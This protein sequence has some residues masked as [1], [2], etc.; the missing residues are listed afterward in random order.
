MN[1]LILFGFF[2]CGL[3]L[4]LA[5]PQ[6]DD[7]DMAELDAPVGND[8]SDMVD[9][10]GG[11]GGKWRPHHRGGKGKR[12]GRG[13]H[14]KGKRGRHGR[15]RFMI[16]RMMMNMSYFKA[17]GA[18]DDCGTVPDTLMKNPMMNGC[19]NVSQVIPFQN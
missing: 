8:I 3:V 2:L 14:G 9:R 4:V 7:L 5:N 12:G 15:R 13:R 16:M 1:K 6:D 17:S 11:K 18:D 10:R 19:K